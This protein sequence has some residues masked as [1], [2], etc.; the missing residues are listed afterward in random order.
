MYMCKLCD[1]DG[2]HKGGILYQT[3]RKWHCIST[4]D[5][6]YNFS[7]KSTY[8]LMLILGPSL[9]AQERTTTGHVLISYIPSG[10]ESTSET[11]MTSRLSTPI[12]RRNIWFTASVSF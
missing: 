11:S 8:R 2:D 6:T 3:L 4:N 5:C 12:G 1:R 7:W 9:M 10:V